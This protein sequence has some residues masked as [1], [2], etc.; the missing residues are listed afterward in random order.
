MPAWQVLERSDSMPSGCEFQADIDAEFDEESSVS[1]WSRGFVLGHDWLSEVWEEY[2]P[3]SV[4]KEFGATVMALSFFSSRR[5]AEAFY[6]ELDP[7][8]RTAPG[9]SLEQFAETIRGL[10]PEALS[11][12]SHLGRTIF[13]ALIQNPATGDS[14]ASSAKIGR[15]D[16]CPCGS[17]KKYKKCCAA[18]LH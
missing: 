4:D 6:A 3:E 15:N 10:F 11:F 17:G 2:L 1:E 16:P 18:K 13:E 7:T 14:P 5:L 9:K 8:V 12:Y